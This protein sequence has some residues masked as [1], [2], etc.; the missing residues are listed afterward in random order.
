MVWAVVIAVLGLAAAAGTAGADVGQRAFTLMG[1]ET[2][3]SDSGAPR[4]PRTGSELASDLSRDVRDVMA[5]PDGRVGVLSAS[6]AIDVIGL[7]GRL[8]RLARLS[9]VPEV[10]D[11][12]DAA[13]DGSLLIISAGRVWRVFDGGLPRR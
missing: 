2:F 13:P 12:A 1:S 6:G 11:A 5:M 10:G 8:A 4:L 9:A 7:D 3:S